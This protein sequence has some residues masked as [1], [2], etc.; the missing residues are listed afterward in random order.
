MIFKRFVRWLQGR[1]PKCG[2][3]LDHSV[4]GYGSKWAHCRNCGYCGMAEAFGVERCGAGQAG[5]QR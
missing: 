5:R 3:E 2:S 4:H 1:C